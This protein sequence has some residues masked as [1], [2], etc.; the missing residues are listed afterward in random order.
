MLKRIGKTMLFSGSSRHASF[1]G[2]S[3]RAS[4]P[5]A[6]LGQSTMAGGCGDSLAGS[7]G[8]AAFDFETAVRKA[9]AIA[10]KRQIW[11][12]GRFF[13]RRTSQGERIRAAPEGQ[14]K[15][16]LPAKPDADD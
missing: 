14:A 8:M 7:E 3:L 9:A 4:E 6:P 10:V 11:W 13:T 5:G 16:S 15:L 1:S 2:S 12:N